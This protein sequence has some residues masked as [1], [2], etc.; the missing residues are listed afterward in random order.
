[1]KARFLRV[2]YVPTK[3][4][5]L[6]CASCGNFRTD[7]AILPAGAAEQDEP[8]QHAHVGVHRACIDNLHSK[9]GT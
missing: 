2:A 1:M 9:R 6:P 5:D 7:F 3:R 8:D 4:T